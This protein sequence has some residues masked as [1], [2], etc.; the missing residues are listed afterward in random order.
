MER[1]TSPSAALACP[2]SPFAAERW[3]TDAP[4]ASRQPLLPR[5]W[6]VC[7]TKPRQE[8]YAVD[9]LQEQ[10]YEVWLPL[11]DQWA[12]RSGAWRK[13]QIVMFPRYAFVRP[14]RAEQGVGAIRSTPGV[15]TLV[16]FGPVLACLAA[17]RVE[18]LRAVVA[19]RAASLP[20]Q[21]LEPGRQ[22]VFSAGP[23]KGLNGIVSAVAAERVRVMMS[24]LGCE[25]TVSV[26][27]DDLALA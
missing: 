10:G 4:P 11:L 20:E 13:N 14:T 15:T 8:R 24:L 18:A 2:G 5:D 1:R 16:R 27:A 9:K 21:P 12:R 23:L 3:A 17:D 19:E 25:Q 22:V 7:L 6:Y 26:R